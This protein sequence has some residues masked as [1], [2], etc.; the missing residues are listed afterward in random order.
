M[1]TMVPNPICAAENVYW[2]QFVTVSFPFSFYA[3]SLLAFP[4]S[5][6]KWQRM[7]VAQIIK[8]LVGI[9]YLFYC[10]VIVKQKKIRWALAHR[11]AI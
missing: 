2:L 10:S 11:I 7:T 9:L 8:V 1:N 5:S 6:H 3:V 4:K